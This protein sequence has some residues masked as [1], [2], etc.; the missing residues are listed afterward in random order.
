LLLAP[1]KIGLHNIAGSVHPIDEMPDI[2]SGA[3]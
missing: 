3:F 1:I 2:G